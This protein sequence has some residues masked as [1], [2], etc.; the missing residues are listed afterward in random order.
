MNAR[1]LQ[2]PAQAAAPTETGYS[3]DTAPRIR[4]Y[5]A[6]VRPLRGV[7]GVGGSEPYQRGRSLIERLALSAHSTDDPTMRLS[8]LQCA[9]VV[10]F[11]RHSEPVTP[12]AWWSEPADAPSHLVGLCFV[13][14]AV[15]TSLRDGGRRS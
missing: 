4:S 11:V 5:L 14:D 12:R 7:A 1:S 9:D 6:H 2:K 3:D 13:L 8:P 15:E 10:H